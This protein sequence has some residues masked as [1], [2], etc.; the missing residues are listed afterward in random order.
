M[1]GWVCY[2]AGHTDGGTAGR[3]H[4]CA[5]ESCWEPSIGSTCHRCLQ[6][7]CSGCSCC[8]QLTDTFQWPAGLISPHTTNTGFTFGTRIMQQ[9]LNWCSLYMGCFE[10]VFLKWRN[11]LQ[12]VLCSKNIL[13]PRPMTH[14]VLQHFSF[15]EYFQLPSCWM[16]PCALVWKFF[17]TSQRISCDMSVIST[18]I[19]SPGCLLYTFH[20]RCPWRISWELL[21]QVNEEAREWDTICCRNKFAKCCDVNSHSVGLS[22]TC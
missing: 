5:E 6:C 1:Q 10:K 13:F 22:V 18:H 19:L 11:I 2:A 4:Q 14:F 20:F 16:H 7:G 9:I 21:G 15:V 3:C 8:C 17:I 12:K